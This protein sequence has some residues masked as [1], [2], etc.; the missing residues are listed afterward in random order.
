MLNAT[1]ITSS[2][3]QNRDSEALPKGWVQHRKKADNGPQ[4]DDDVGLRFKGEISDRHVLKDTDDYKDFDAYIGAEV[5]LPQ[6]E[7]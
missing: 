4:Y 2:C 3:M 5:L 6:N 1:V 7:I